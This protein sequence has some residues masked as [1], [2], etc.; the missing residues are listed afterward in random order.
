MCRFLCCLPPIVDF[1]QSMIKGVH[2]S[3]MFRSPFIVNPIL[4]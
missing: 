2:V 3:D 4:S 1:S